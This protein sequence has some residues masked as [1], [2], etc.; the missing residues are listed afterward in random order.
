M[1]VVEMAKKLRDAIVVYRIISDPFEK[2]PE[3]LGCK[4]R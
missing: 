3:I 1:N 2:Y 4:L